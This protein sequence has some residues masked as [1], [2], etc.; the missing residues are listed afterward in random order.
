MVSPVTALTNAINRYVVRP[1]N[2]FGIGGFVFDVEGETTVNLKADITDHYLEDNSTIQDHIAIRPKKV[3]LRSYVG[4]LIY[5]TEGNETTNVEKAV[6]KL[7]TLSAY[8]PQVTSTVQ[9]IQE[10]NAEDLTGV[11][12]SLENVTA[13]TVNKA[14]DYYTLAQN[15]LNGDSAQQ[16]AYM[17]LKSLMEQKILVS[18]QT[19]FEYMN[20]MAIESVV[21]RQGEDSKFISDFSITLKQIRIAEILTLPTGETTYQ[22]EQG[23]GDTYQGRSDSQYQSVSNIGSVSGQD[24][25]VEDLPNTGLPDELVDPLVFTPSEQDLINAERFNSS[26]KDI[27]NQPVFE[28]FKAGVP[29]Q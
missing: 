7:T 9:Q 6:R 29:Y 19:P 11:V 27:E 3:T 14:T 20:N 18:L 8:L 10:L 12:D 23:D 13:Q 17:Y 22:T 25:I 15:L 5:E 2:A 16:D 4:E 21:A 28:A 1:V 26:G 24:A